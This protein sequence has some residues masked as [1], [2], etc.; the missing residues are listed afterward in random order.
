MIT[1]D[2][3][4][5]LGFALGFLIAEADEAEEAELDWG[6]IIFLGPISFFIEKEKV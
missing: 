4:F 2:Y 1:L 6:V 5:N 3:S